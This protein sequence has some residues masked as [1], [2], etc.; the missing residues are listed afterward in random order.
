MVAGNPLAQV[1]IWWLAPRDAGE[2]LFALSGPGVA[3][4]SGFICPVMSLG[5][6]PSYKHTR[7]A[8]PLWHWRLPGGTAGPL[9]SEADCLVGLEARCRGS[10]QVSVEVS[11]CLKASVTV[12]KH[13]DRKSS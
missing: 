9:R 10:F 3:P 4:R 11:A 8:T 13:H 7:K 5:F 2:Q 6:C 12:M 1:T